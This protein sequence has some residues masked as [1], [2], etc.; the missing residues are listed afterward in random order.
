MLI[1][2]NNSLFC[3]FNESLEDR[4]I[5][6]PKFVLIESIK[7]ICLHIKSEKACVDK[8]CTIKPIMNRLKCQELLHLET[9]KVS[10]G[11]SG[12]LLYKHKNEAVQKIYYYI[13]YR[14][15]CKMGWGP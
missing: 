5:F 9:E 4:Q 15:R 14:H 2:Y 13:M 6:P 7:T 3:I 12:L 10:D 1:Y 11:V 8:N